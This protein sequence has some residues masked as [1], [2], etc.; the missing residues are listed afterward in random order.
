MEL[1]RLTVETL[2]EFLNYFDHRAFL[3]NQEWAGCY[4][5]FYLGSANNADLSSEEKS[6][7]NRALACSRVATGEMEGYLLFDGDQMVGWCAAGSSLLYPNVPDAQE[8][9]A[10]VLCFN[11][12]P[13]WRGQGIA[14]T[15]LEKVVADLSARGFEAVEGAPRSSETSIKSYRGTVSMFLTQGFEQVVE[16]GDGFV[17]MRKY[18]T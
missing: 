11:I 16:L 5:Q 7:Q 3:T 13:D 2:D 4:C 17:L 1:K 9:L 18:L 8:K 10:R 14:S 15:L 6:A 12:D